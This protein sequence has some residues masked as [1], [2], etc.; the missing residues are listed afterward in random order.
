MDYN[1]IFFAVLVVTAIVVIVVN[2]KKKRWYTVYME[3]NDVFCAYRKLFDWWMIDMSGML[4]FHDEDGKII[5][6]SKHKIIKVV[7]GIQP[8]TTVKG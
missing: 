8:P 7:E 4:G 3:N 5:K 6:V 2:A 1:L